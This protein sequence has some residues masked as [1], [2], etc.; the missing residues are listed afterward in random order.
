MHAHRVFITFVI[1]VLVVV[2]VG[3]RPPERAALHRGISPYG[4]HKLKPARRLKRFVGEIPVVKTG[5]GKHAH[6]IEKRG[7]RECSPAEPSPNH[8][9]A[10]RVEKDVR[11]KTDRIDEIG[12]FIEVAFAAGDDVV[13]IEHVKK[14]GLGAG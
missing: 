3:A 12:I 4:H 11:D 14:H 5:N 13:G 10:A 8:E 1:R 2:A 7:H 9:Q 6:E